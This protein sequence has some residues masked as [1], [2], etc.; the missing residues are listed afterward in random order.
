M[1][2]TVEV[3]GAFTLIFTVFNAVL[4]VLMLH[5]ALL[6][7]KNRRL[8]TWI[9]NHAGFESLNAVRDHYARGGMSISHEDTLQIIEDVTEDVK[10][11]WKTEPSMYTEDDRTNLLN[12]GAVLQ[13]RHMRANEARAK[14]E[15]EKKLEEANVYSTAL[16]KCQRMSDGRI[17]CRGVE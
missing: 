4:G 10:G 12:L 9:Y 17:V 8:I 2:S 13:Q 11:D 5:L 6:K 15:L 16:D 3:L 1:A 7:E 14:K